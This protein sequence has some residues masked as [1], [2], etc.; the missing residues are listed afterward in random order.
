MLFSWRASL[1]GT[2]MFVP[3]AEILHLNRSGIR[4]F[5]AYQRKIGAAAVMYRSVVSPGAIRI[6][7]C[8][9]IASVLLPLVIVPWI[10][11][12][13]LGRARLRDLISFLLFLP[14]CFAGSFAWAWGFRE[15]LNRG[16]RQ[17]S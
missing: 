8:L 9:P 17:P 14:L 7:R 16:A 1:K 2:I 12:V 11:L 13:M 10:A 5:L 3:K 4:L 6:F 15:A